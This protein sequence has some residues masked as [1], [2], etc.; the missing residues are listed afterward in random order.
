MKLFPQMFKV[1]SVG[2]VLGLAL[3]IGG[4]PPPPPPGR[5]PQTVDKYDRAWSAVIGALAYEQV[6]IL[7]QDPVAGNVRG[8]L[9]DATVTAN[10]ARQADGSVRVE[11]GVSG[12]LAA[13]P[14]LKERLAG[15]Y[16]RRMG[17]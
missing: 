8:S 1:L 3:A 4:C 17:R 15:S 5:P 12:N 11:F 13:H 9:G 7:L 10:V 2:L 16:N 14:N 6:M